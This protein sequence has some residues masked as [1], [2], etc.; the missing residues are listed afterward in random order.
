MDRLIA[1]QAYVR[2]VEVGNFSRVAD[3]MRV[4]QSTI[5]KWLSALETEIGVKLLDRTTRRQRVTDAGQ[6]FYEHARDVITRYEEALA[7]IQQQAPQLSGRLRVS[8]PA[9]F[10]HRYILPHLPAF[11]DAH[12][13]VELEMKFS[14]RYVNLVEEGVDLVIRVGLPVPSSFIGRRLG[15]TPR[16]LVASPGYL[17]QAPALSRPADLASHRCLL[18]TGRSQVIWTFHHNDTQQR[19]S[20]RGRFAADSSEALRVAACADQGV[21]LLA[22]WLVRADLD[23]GRLVLLLGTW[24]LPPAPIRA[25]TPPGRA[26]H[27]RVRAFLTHLVEAWGPTLG[28]QPM[29]ADPTSD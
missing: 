8:V 21:A 2:L 26:R 1:L 29:T 5:S 4:Q 3:E 14:D 23:A 12:P 16:R 10:G 27:P 6:R 24:T 28:A 11:L 18:H 17:A 25:V 20:V 13:N 9:V 7:D 19:V 22:D 15:G